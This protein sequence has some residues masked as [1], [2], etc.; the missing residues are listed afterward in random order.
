M[1][2]SIV[3]QTKRLILRRLHLTDAAQVQKLAGAKEIAMNT[4]SI[5]HP[6]QDGVAEKWI[7]L[8]QKG[9]ERGH[10]FNLAIVEKQTDFLCGS[11]GLSIDKVHDRAELGYWIGVEFWGRGYCT[12]A[13]VAVINYG[14]E[15]LNLHRIHASY[16]TRN[17][18]SGRVMQK[19]GMTYEGCCQQH[20]K[21][22]GQ[23]Q[24]LALYGI[25][26]SQWRDRQSTK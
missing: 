1:N 13:A 5:P 10:L 18:A 19:I 6:Y 20:I 25:L 4:L 21:K 17:S 23:F 15:V 9:F 16:L 8:S 3:L 26:A 2:A 12:E 11:I 14:F 22:W 7:E 24:D